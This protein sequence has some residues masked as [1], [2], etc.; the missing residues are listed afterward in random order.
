MFLLTFKFLGWV[1]VST[2]WL[3]VLACAGVL[4]SFSFPVFA[5]TR[6]QDQELQ[7]ARE[8]EAAIRAQQPIP[9]DPTVPVKPPP[10]K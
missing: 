1:V 6:P 3:S 4:G 10:G 7:R 2:N 5:Q 9:P 8:R